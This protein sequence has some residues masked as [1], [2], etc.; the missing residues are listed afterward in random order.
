MWLLGLP[1][2]LVPLEGILLSLLPEFGLWIHDA[3]PLF[4][5][6]WVM[7]IQTLV[8]TFVGKA[9]CQLSQPS[10]PR[11]TV[12]NPRAG[13]VSI[14]WAAAMPLLLWALTLQGLPK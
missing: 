7:G 1:S 4:I 11:V 9:L 13:S 14:P 3:V 5:K 8:L 10:A 6:T 12:I 2:S